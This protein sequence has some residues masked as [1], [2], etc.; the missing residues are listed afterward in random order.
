MKTKTNV[1]CYI[2]DRYAE[3]GVK[4][5]EKKVAKLLND[6]CITGEV[7]CLNAWKERG[8]GYGQYLDCL[9]IEV[10]GQD[11]CLRQRT[12]DSVAWD[13]WNDP[14]AK[15]KRNLFVAVLENTIEVLIE[16]VKENNDNE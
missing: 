11:Y 14:T 7:V 1:S 5:F 2:Y 6:N 4:A 12:N 10:N 9:E 8:N 13:E 16:E 15:D 3:I